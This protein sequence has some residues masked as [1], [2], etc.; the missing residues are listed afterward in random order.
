MY[1]SAELPV[2]E[3]AEELAEKASL[4][5]RS[6]YRHLMEVAER[7]A[8]EA[9]LVVSGRAATRLLLGDP[10][11]PSRPPPVGL[12]SF[13]CEYVGSDAPRQAKALADAIW[14][15]EPLGL[16]HYAMMLS[17]VPGKLMVVL[18]NG[19]AL[20]TVQSLPTLRGVPA[21]DILVPS[22]RPAQFARDDTGAPL[23]LPCVGPELQLIGTYAALANPSKAS[24]WGDL[25][26]EEA[27]L[28][29]LYY[30][31]AEKKHAMA[32]ARRTELHGRERDLAESESEA[33][34]EAGPDGES[35]GWQLG[36]SSL[37]ALGA[38]ATPEASGL[39]RALLDHFA[40]G[41]GRVLVGP[42][43]IASITGTRR[44]ASGHARVQVVSAGSL[45]EEAKIA[46]AIAKQFGFASDWAVNDPGCP[47]DPRLRRAT[48]YVSRAGRREPVLD[49][50]NSAAYELV[51]YATATNWEAVRADFPARA[52]GGG[53]APAAGPSRTRDEIGMGG[54]T[55]TATPLSAPDPAAL[56]I[57]TPFV[58]MRY[59][60]ADMWT[61]QALLRMGA[62]SG[63][64]ARG[65]LAEM[66]DDYRAV[67]GRY[68]ELLALL[69]A[70]GPR[71]AVIACILPLAHEAGA[72][73]VGRLEDPE[74]AMRRAVASR[75][76][77][78]RYPAYYPA[79]SKS[80][81]AP[82][83]ESPKLTA[84]GAG[85]SQGGDSNNGL[86]CC[87]D[88]APCRSARG[89]TK[90]GLAR[91]AQWEDAWFDSDNED[92]Y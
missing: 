21:A 31:E 7:F 23:L 3:P 67:A 88:Y 75:P 29:A 16:G 40:T 2:V 68:S 77:Q 26:S 90:G 82:M 27:A 22:R 62:V 25:L 8:V 80:A 46:G 76:D 53:R 6:P 47:V 36:H 42:Y 51:P 11:D 71:S 12:D 32:I 57:G 72:A 30:R 61:I 28:R 54:E 13:Q 78:R 19:R 69:A 50:F 14:E 34:A 83:A 52:S 24:S 38:R 70:D 86:L 48:V 39:R 44:A 33:E 66:L 59:R 91:R 73:Y 64:F 81:K 5:D 18:A 4:A 87:G 74:L 17:K 20:F 9:G 89:A 58:L 45:E 85:L 65:V 43:A 79:A 92:H 60:L 63:A 15:A 10:A 84:E 37:E 49:V 41:P 55:A 56:K 35:P 1:R